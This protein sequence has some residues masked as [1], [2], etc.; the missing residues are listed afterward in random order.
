MHATQYGKYTYVFFR[1]TKHI[2]VR[3]LPLFQFAG[4]II[5]VHMHENNELQYMMLSLIYQQGET[6][7][8]FTYINVV[9]EAGRT[10]ICAHD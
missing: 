8:I 6:F 7:K 1:H 10:T 5:N 3:D 2:Y 4:N 9:V